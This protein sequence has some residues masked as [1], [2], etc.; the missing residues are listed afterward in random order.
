MFGTRLE[1]SLSVDNKKILIGHGPPL[2]EEKKVLTLLLVHFG[3][4]GTRCG[5]KGFLPAQLTHTALFFFAPRS[6]AH[7]CLLACSGGNYW[8]RHRHRGE[9]RKQKMKPAPPPHTRVKSK[10]EKRSNSLSLSVTLI[11]S[12]PS[13]KPR[14][15][16]G[17]WMTSFLLPLPNPGMSPLAAA[18]AVAFLSPPLRFSSFAFGKESVWTGMPRLSSRCALCN[19]AQQRSF[20]GGKLNFLGGNL[21]SVLCRDTDLRSPP[22]TYL[23]IPMRRPKIY[24]I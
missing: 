22:P 5:A 20:G 12:P 13:R 15:T 6:F 11:S 21:R 3:L 17:L 7:P 2:F 19:Y 10:G 23:P 14:M 16:L 18:A 24:S 1:S 4:R 8:R 9:K